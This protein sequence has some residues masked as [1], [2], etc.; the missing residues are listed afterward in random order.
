[1]AAASA[2]I[3]TVWLGARPPVVGWTVTALA[4]AITG[5]VVVSAASL[6]VPRS[7]AFLGST[8]GPGLDLAATRC[9]GFYGTTEY[10]LGLPARANISV[11]VCL[12]GSTVRHTWGKPDCWASDTALAVVVFPL[13]PCSVTTGAD[14]SMVISMRSTGYGTW[15]PYTRSV[16]ATWRIRP[17][18]SVQQLSG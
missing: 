5:L 2:A 18:G 15:W 16:H 1:M 13:P 11:G 7:S 14:G 4:A 17:D 8:G 9:G 6:V 12:D 3:L 10:G